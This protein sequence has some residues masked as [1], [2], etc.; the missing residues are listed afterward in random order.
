M[1]SPFSPLLFIICFISIIFL[2]ERERK[3]VKQHKSQMRT[4]IN[5]FSFKCSI[6][7]LNLNMAHTNITKVTLEAVRV[8]P[9]IR[10]SALLKAFGFRFQTK[11]VGRSQELLKTGHENILNLN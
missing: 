1:E 5:Y 6:G 8:S 3:L 10:V 7:P 11:T 2:Q 9:L 4:F